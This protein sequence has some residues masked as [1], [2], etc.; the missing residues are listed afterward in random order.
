MATVS[1]GPEE[2]TPGSASRAKARTNGKEAFRSLKT[3]RAANSV[4]GSS[5]TAWASERFWAA[6]EP[7]TVR[8]LV[9]SDSSWGWLRSSARA[10]VSKL[11]TSPERSWTLVPNRAWLTS[12]VYL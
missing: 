2:R 9:T 10:T 4:P 11:E 1:V 3:G 8:R 5:W 7:V 12:E 6:K